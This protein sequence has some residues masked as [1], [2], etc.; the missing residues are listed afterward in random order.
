MTKLLN[1]TATITQPP[2]CGSVILELK[3][4]KRD[5]NYYVQVF[6]KNNTASEEIKLYNVTIY[7][8]EYLL[9]YQKV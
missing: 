6:L 7:G 9:A 8:L 4:S 2:Y 5:Q 3:K 1:L